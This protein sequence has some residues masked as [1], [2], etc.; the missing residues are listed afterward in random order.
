MKKSMLT[1]GIAV[2]ILTACGPKAIIKEANPN[3]DPAVSTR[4][5]V[6]AAQIDSLAG[7][8]W[9][10]QTLGLE[11]V[12]KTV[13][14]STRRIKIAIVSSGIDYN[15]PDLR[16]N[17]L[18]NLGELQGSDVNEDA[19]LVNNKIDGKD[20]DG[21]G[22]DDDVVGYDFVENDGYAY[23]RSGHGTA[24]AGVIG[25]IHNNGIGI[26][27]VL[28]Q[29]S[30]V[31]VR[32]IDPN[33]QATLPRMLD[34]LRYATAVNSDVVYLHLA[35]VSLYQGAFWESESETKAAQNAE[36]Q[37][38]AKAAADL[39][40]KG[41]PLVISAGNS[42]ENID[43]KNE[44]LSTLR[45]SSN[46][47][48]VTSTDSQDAKPFIANYGPQTVDIGAP[49]VGVMTTA[50]GGSYT[51]QNGSY[52]AGGYVTGALGLAVAKSYGVYAPAALVTKLKSASGGDDVTSLETNTISGR[53]L[54]VQK[55]IG[56]L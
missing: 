33:G 30:L 36:K 16:N 22:Y 56:S 1:L 10:T 5:V 34:A 12:W 48:V 32:Y 45:R 53:R 55:Y 24:I 19:A 29:V 31:P 42:A 44:I 21:N 4:S 15:H 37:A 14:T 43:G 13:N 8:Q 40:K 6:P 7:N 9:S 47:I 49:G 51:E 50:P 54:N 23:D 41:V 28:D 26:K 2:L 46:V 25:A 18:V 38:I 11:S 20:T 17:V 35:N 27:G 52:L 3:L 39:E